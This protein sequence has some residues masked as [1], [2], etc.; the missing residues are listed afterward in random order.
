MGGKHGKTPASKVLEEK[1]K[2]NLDQIC[3]EMSQSSFK[4]EQT[5]QK[6]KLDFK[7]LHQSLENISE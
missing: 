4:G 3:E 6:I 2:E 5:V 7:A 1:K